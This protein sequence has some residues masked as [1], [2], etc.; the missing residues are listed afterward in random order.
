MKGS[1]SEERLVVMMVD[2]ISGLFL[3]GGRFRRAFSLGSATFA[4]PVR[5]GCARCLRWNGDDYCTWAVACQPKTRCDAPTA[6]TP[7]VIVA[8]SAQAGL[9]L[10]SLS[11]ALNL[12]QATTLG[13][14]YSVP[15]QHEL[16]I[17]TTANSIPPI[18]PDY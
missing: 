7:D 5:C 1:K 11:A 14:K 18:Y 9:G 2:L 8:P 10:V 12:Q 16:C 3:F 6:G 13:P 15:L 17:G 4:L